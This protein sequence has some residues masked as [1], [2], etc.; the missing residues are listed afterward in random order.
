MQKRTVT[1]NYEN[2]LAMCSKGQRRNHKL[3]EWSV[4]FINWARGLPYA[5]NLIFLDE[6]EK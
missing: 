1:M 5:E 4:A 6:V 3:S 2:L